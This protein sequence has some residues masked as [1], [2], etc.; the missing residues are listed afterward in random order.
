MRVLVTGH[1]GYIGHRLVPRLLE[2]GH[3]V[4]GCDSFLFEGTGF[5]ADPAPIE[6]RRT[7]VRD[8]G[9]ADL[10]GFD[11]VLHLAALSNDPLGDLDPELTLEINHRA[12]VRL[13]EL[14]RA[15]GAERFIFFSSCSVYGASPDRPVDESSERDPLTAYGYSKIYAERDIAALA[16]ESFSPVFL[17][18]ATA[19][20]LSPRH[21]G[22]LVVNSLVGHA[23]TSGRVHLQSD[24]S[25]VRPLVHI[26]DIASAALAA[27][28][29]PREAIHAEVLNIGR[30]DENHTMA[31][32]AEI[33]RDLVPGSTVSFADSAGPDRRSYRASF[34][35]AAERLRGF[36]PRWTVRE[37]AREMLEA[38]RE[39]AIDAESFASSR[40]HRIA[41]L[42]E[43]M[44]AGSL[45]PDLRR[46]EG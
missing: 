40:F 44:T 21:R 9:P 3:A 46:R 1:D 14:A 15:A 10:Q 33:V 37:G 16:S 8:L 43:Q 22:D 28:E 23:V 39:H 20:G 4:V 35:K 26:D 19:Y 42:R 45:G 17:R 18:N 29:A 30:D 6:E 5:E 13:A 31:G 32:V 11:A 41:H 34:R 7:D 38:Y 27:L 12:S 24:G 36:E 2:R 25:P